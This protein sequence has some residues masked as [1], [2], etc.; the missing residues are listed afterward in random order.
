MKKS[1]KLKGMTLFE[2]II[3][4][5]VFAGFGVILITAGVSIDKISKATTNLKGK[6]VVQSSYAA[7]KK[8]V[9]DTDPYTGADIKLTDDAIQISVNVNGAS[10]WYLKEDDSSPTGYELADDG[11]SPKKY[12]YANPSAVLNAN[13]YNTEEIILA[14]KTDGMTDEEKAAYKD[15]YEANVNGNLNFKFIEI[16]TTP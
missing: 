4:L 16:T 3:A 9:Y 11:V 8:T 6:M 2:I 5:A 1:K 14:E 10:G 15:E 7:N 13:K 12:T